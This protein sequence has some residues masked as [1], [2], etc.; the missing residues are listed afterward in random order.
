MITY[1]K[2]LIRLWPVG[3]GVL[4]LVGSTAWWLHRP[5]ASPD[6]A[7]NAVALPAASSASSG[8][9]QGLLPADAA[10]AAMAILQSPEI[11]PD[12]RPS[13]IPADEWEALKKAAADSPNAQ[14]ELVRLVKFLRFQR[15]IEAWQAM[16]DDT[17]DRLALGRKL[18]DELPEHLA[19]AEVSMPEA[20]MLCAAILH[21]NQSGDSV[22]DQKVQQCQTRLE[23]SLPPPDKEKRR[24]E[25][26]CKADWEERKARLTADFM[27][28]SPA[29]R[30]EAQ[31]QFE[32][33]LEA[34]RIDVYGSAA[35]SDSF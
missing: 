14:A 19:N 28:K 33:E 32:Q 17:A 8:G 15:G 10:S 24:K 4:L 6:A 22:V 1:D 26:A 13:D 31:A 12:G 25:E 18:V 34:A 23:Q 9:E 3:L 2:S 21:G 29:E 16:S 30:A 27:K 35:C 20:L 5:E 7:T 11:L